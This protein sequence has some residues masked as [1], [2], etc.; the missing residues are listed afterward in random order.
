[1]G[2]TAPPPPAWPPQE[3]MQ[4]DSWV[5]GGG[6]GRETLGLVRH[7]KELRIRALGEGALEEGCFPGGAPAKLKK[8]KET[9]GE[10]LQEQRC[11]REGQV[12]RAAGTVPGLR[13]QERTQG[14]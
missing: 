2:E 10:W 7:L 14:R 13:A 6:R 1:M 4:S 5:L 9:A 11:A 3:V 8:V 12:L